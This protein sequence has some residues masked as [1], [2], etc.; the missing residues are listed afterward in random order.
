MELLGSVTKNLRAEGKTK[1][2][3]EIYQLGEYVYGLETIKAS[4]V[5]RGTSM[6]ITLDHNI[7]VNKD[8]LVALINS[9]IHE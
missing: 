7:K 3:D 2:A 9:Q 4:G 8:H 5:Y 1:L 6:E